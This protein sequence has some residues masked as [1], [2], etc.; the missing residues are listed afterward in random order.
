VR[1]ANAVKVLVQLHDKPR[2]VC[3][4]VDGN[5]KR[6]D[7]DGTLGPGEGYSGLT[8]MQKRATAI[9]ARLQIKSAPGR[10]A[11]SAVIPS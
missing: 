1:H 2:Q 3:L 8:G 11:I 6:F 4:Q 9:N 7:P 10:T 5:G